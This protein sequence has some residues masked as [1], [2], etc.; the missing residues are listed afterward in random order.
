MCLGSDWLYTGDPGCGNNVDG[1]DRTS[2]RIIAFDSMFM[3]RPHFTPQS[4]VKEEPKCSARLSLQVLHLASE[5]QSRI[6]FVS[7]ASMCLVRPDQTIRS[8]K[9]FK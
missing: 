6:F 1:P 8:R 3:T 2:A 7:E 4:K 9:N 5:Q